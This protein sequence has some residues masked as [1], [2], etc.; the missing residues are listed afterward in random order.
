MEIFN[1]EQNKKIGRHMENGTNYHIIPDHK[2]HLSKD[3][4]ILLCLVTRSHFFFR[5]SQ[6]EVDVNWR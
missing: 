4:I 3:H 2:M 1:G 6:Y 5:K